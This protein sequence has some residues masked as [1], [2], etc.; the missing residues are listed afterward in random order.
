[1]NRSEDQ[2]IF[3]HL[4]KQRPGALP[5]LPVLA[6]CLLLMIWISFGI[7]ILVV[8]AGDPSSD[9][10]KFFLFI[11]D[12]LAALASSLLLT[13]LI[14]STSTLG[15]KLLGLLAIAVGLF[16]TTILFGGLPTLTPLLFFQILLTY[17]SG[18]FG[19]FVASG[20]FAM[21]LKYR[22]DRSNT[23][24]PVINRNSSRYHKL[25]G[26]VGG[27]EATARRLI[28]HER[29]IHPDHNGEQ[30]IQDAL[31]NLSIDRNRN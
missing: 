4:L 17:L 11:A 7:R 19:G 29:S 18:E 25:L 3:D 22:Q 26:R 28:A 31:D 15:G 16:F 27:N 9:S 30:L 24:S 12:P 13:Y 21:R 20:Q 10:G 6:G 2:G 5:T 14:K 8:W 1:M 23:A